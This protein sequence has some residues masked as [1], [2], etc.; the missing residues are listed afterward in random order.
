[1]YLHVRLGGFKV[2]L[3]H[4]FVVCLDADVTILAIMG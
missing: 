2:L 1:M 4:W 3:S